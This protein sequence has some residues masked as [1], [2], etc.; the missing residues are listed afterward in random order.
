MLLIRSKSGWQLSSDLVATAAVAYKFS[1]INL[2]D[3]QEHDPSSECIEIRK[4]KL[5]IS[6]AALTGLY[7]AVA[8]NWKLF[9]GWRPGAMAYAHPAVPDW[10]GAAGDIQKLMFKQVI[11]KQAVAAA[12]QDVFSP[13]DTEWDFG[14]DPITANPTVNTFGVWINSTGAGAFAA[15]FINWQVTYRWKA[16][17]QNDLQSYLGWEALG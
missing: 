14:A 8:Q 6:M 9:M 16:A 15:D 10:G 7:T 4:I 2:P 11:S 13:I 1:N 12:A 5:S 17:K 3:Y